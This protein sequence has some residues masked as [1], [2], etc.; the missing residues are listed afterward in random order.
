M[1]ITN[2]PVLVTGVTGFIAAETARQLLEDG[3]RVRGTTRSVSRAIDA[4]FLMSLPGAQ[5][6]LELVEANLLDSGSLD[7][8]VAGCEYVMHIA[9]PYIMDVEDPQRDLVDP[10]VKGTVSVLEAASSSG[11]VKRVV[12]TSSAAAI[13]GEPGT[14]AWT[15]EDWN[16][17][18]TIDNVPYSYS[19]TMAERSAWDYVGSVKPD[20][21]LVVINPTGVIG[22]SIVQ[23]LNQSMATLVNLTNGEFPGIIGLGFAYV[24]VRDVARAHILA[25][26]TQTASGRYICSAD[27]VSIRHT[28]E[29]MREMGIDERYKLP[30]IPLDNVLGN[31][32][33]RLAANFQPKGTRAFLKVYVGHDFRVD[34]TRIRT[35][36]GM[37]FRDIDET[38][39]DA[40]TNAEKWGHLGEKTRVGVDQFAG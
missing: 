12:L 16:D 31:A 22:P 38:L 15:E 7:A 14:R 29:V 24:D 2:A 13:A 26:E 11:A 33:V 10:A 27:T 35:E 37:T 17:V 32:V 30:S 36:L 23:R 39:R 6:R 8:A 20:F 3:Y 9:S 1:T 21:D 5:D 4:G 40:I 25:M 18:S 19:K 28:V 34:A